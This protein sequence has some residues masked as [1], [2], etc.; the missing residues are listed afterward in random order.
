MEH[1]VFL[2]GLS[3]KFSEEQISEFFKATLDV[4]VKHV[5]LL[6]NKKKRYTGCAVVELASAG[7]VQKIL[8]KE[9]FELRGRRFFAKPHLSGE[10]LKKYQR[11]VKSKRVFIHNVDP[12]FTNKDIR[13][14]FTQL[15]PIEDAFLIESFDPSK[16]NAL[17]YGYVMF[18]H[19]D[20]AQKMIQKGSLKVKGCTIIIMPYG[21]DA[22]GNGVPGY[23]CGPGCAQNGSGGKIRQNGV[24]GGVVSTNG[25]QASQL[26]SK[27]SSI[28]SAKQ[29]KAP[30]GQLRRPGRGS[31][32]ITPFALPTD[33]EM[34]IGGFAAENYHHQQ[35]QQEFFD[36]CFDP[37]M[38]TLGGSLGGVDLQA[39]PNGGL[40]DAYLTQGGFG[41]E[42]GPYSNDW[43]AGFM[44]AQQYLFAAQAANF[45]TYMQQCLGQGVMDQQKQVKTQN[46]PNFDSKNQSSQKTK[47]RLKLSKKGNKGAS[48]PF[49]AIQPSSEGPTTPLK[50]SKRNSGNT[51]VNIDIPFPSS[52]QGATQDI[53]NHS[54]TP[55]NNN[56]KAKTKEV[57]INQVFLNNNPENHQNPHFQ[58]NS[59]NNNH[60]QIHST[61]FYSGSYS[62][63]LTNHDHTVGR[64]LSR[65]LCDHLAEI[66]KARAG[67]HKRFNLSFSKENRLRSSRRREVMDRLFKQ[68]EPQQPSQ[69]GLA[70]KHL[71]RRGRFQSESGFVREFN[72]F[73]YSISSEVS[74]KLFRM[75]LK[76]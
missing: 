16:A 35:P 17:K 30:R 1:K 59:H 56:R 40:G 39:C 23:L 52:P 36:N 65:M 74:S 32:E 47:K 54:N 9:R 5:N 3:V 29:G 60:Q 41:G 22:G 11:E 51:G 49:P 55:K 27:K 14:I 75:G 2:V 6:K 42:M 71:R 12:S 7:G 38:A 62:P 10:K 13:A 18:K 68:M 44:M 15:A 33:L 21:D 28:S 37:Y 26:G 46:K 70:L 19:L 20:D 50:L 61:D 69:E 72:N 34:G 43:A 53:N 67:N 73:N 76:K 64:K 31:G 48:F 24:D 66:P 4:Q 8:N 25:R 63:L 57:R 45:N 58:L